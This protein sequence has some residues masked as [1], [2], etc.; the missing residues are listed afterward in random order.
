MP[1]E[2]PLTSGERIGVRRDGTH[3]PL[4]FSVSSASL[5]RTGTFTAIVRDIT[6]RRKVEEAMDAAA[7]AQAANR[8]KS[9]FLANMSHEIRT[10]MS[11]VLGMAEMLLETDL[12]AVQRRYA[13][14]VH[15]SGE[16]LLKIIDGILDF[17]KIEAGKVELE[18]VEFKPRELMEEVTQLLRDGAEKKG[19][20]FSCRVSADVPETLR[21][22]PSRLQQVLINLV[23]NAIKF[24]DH[25][26][27]A[28]AVSTLDAD[29]ETT[30]ILHV[31]VNDTGIGISPEAQR[32]LFRAFEQADS[33]TTRSYGGTGLGLAISRELVEQMGGRIGVHSAPG[34]GSQFWFSVPLD[35]PAL[36]ASRRAADG[37]DADRPLRLDGV[38]VLLAEDNPINQDVALTML[39]SL[40]CRVHV[41]DN[42]VKALAALAEGEYDIVL[43][44][45]QMPEMD[46][47]D[48]TA[49]I[50]AR[51]LVRPMQPHG[52]AQPVPLPV[53]GLTA[54][55]L[56]GDREMCIAAGM[57]D[58]LAKPY[59]RDALRRLLERWVLDYP[60]A[61][62]GAMVPD[63]GETLNR[64]TLEQLYRRSRAAGPRLV[65]A[66]TDEF[67]REAASL[68]DTLGG[69][70]SRS[71]FGVVAHAAHVLAQR[72]AFVGA[73]RLS[74]LCE[75]LERA[76]LAEDA[77][78]VGTRVPAIR[79]EL[80]AVR[81][82]MSVVRAAR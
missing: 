27:V 8:A 81:A 39:Q 38:R 32:R 74:G 42:G 31:A 48:T 71:E 70:A 11:G 79:E 63:A 49:E 21:G 35:R 66:L 61:E 73:Q 67:S 54:S 56:K 62:A 59:R 64:A 47:F 58:Y 36:R 33:S 69:A 17:S 15:R 22:A 14:S 44:D 29:S 65:A 53:V 2:R 6:D 23:G 77:E 1:A 37:A 16:S 78:S 43:M 76:G 5:D 25:G 57:D 50:R 82:A 41:V 40:G 20:A 45:R 28:I 13:E 7:A 51:G 18:R 3:F 26:H 80:D 12:T 34:Q 30:A 9:R 55:A 68:I 52:A 72:G 46:G 24:T 75:E 10:P 60:P 4:E 19:L